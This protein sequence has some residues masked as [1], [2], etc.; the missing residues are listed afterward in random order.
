MLDNAVCPIATRY[1]SAAHPNRGK[2]SAAAVTDARD[3]LVTFANGFRRMC[4]KVSGVSWYRRT[5]KN[6][7]HAP[8][9]ALQARLI[10]PRDI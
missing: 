9:F 7:F 10:R 2:R 3:R 8:Y 4:V 5:E 6:D 1:R